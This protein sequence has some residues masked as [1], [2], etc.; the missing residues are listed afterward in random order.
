MAP[1]LRT[2]R[3]ARMEM[4]CP[5]SYR[6]G[7]SSA[8]WLNKISFGSSALAALDCRWF[9]MFIAKGNLFHRQ[10]ALQRRKCFESK[11]KG[12][13]LAQSIGAQQC[14]HLTLGS[15]R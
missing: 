9:T 14:V 1:A 6:G 8:S 2:P 15:L 5:P 3:T 10:F 4:N 11:F 13:S 12:G 7:A